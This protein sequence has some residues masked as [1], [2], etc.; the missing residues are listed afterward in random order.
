MIKEQLSWQILALPELL[1]F[2]LE[3]I[4][5]RYVVLVLLLCV[6]E[7]LFSVF[8]KTRKNTQKDFQ[9]AGISLLP[10]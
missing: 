4:R 2:L 9:S 8:F 5:M 1:G 7:G 6:T 10:L 3:Y